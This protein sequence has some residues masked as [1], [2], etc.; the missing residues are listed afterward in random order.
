M[1]N[2]RMGKDFRVKDESSWSRVMYYRFKQKNT[3]EKA[4][5]LTHVFKNCYYSRKK[6][7]V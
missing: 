1:E 7:F 4:S 6:S 5:D 3:V 2:R